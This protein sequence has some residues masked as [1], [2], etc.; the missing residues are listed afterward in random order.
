MTMEHTAKGNHK[1][2]ENCMFAFNCTRSGRPHHYRDGGDGR[3]SEG[4]VL[5][6]I[7]DMFTFEE[8]QAATGCRLI[9]AED[10]K[11]MND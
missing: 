11:P 7:N 3:D 10:L 1:I 8:V 9:P 2:L 4:L 6:E 5:K